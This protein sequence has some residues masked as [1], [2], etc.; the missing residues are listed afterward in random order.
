LS[1]DLA[2]PQ[3]SFFIYTPKSDLLGFATPI[4]AAL[5]RSCS[6]IMT[7]HLKG[8]ISIRQEQF[9]PGVSIKEISA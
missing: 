5:M 8:N 1:Y 7:W 2:I 3:A 9:L 6:S 4:I